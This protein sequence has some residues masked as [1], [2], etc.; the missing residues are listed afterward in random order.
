MTQ[1]L[2]PSQVTQANDGLFAVLEQ[3]LV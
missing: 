2:C 3:V 1:L